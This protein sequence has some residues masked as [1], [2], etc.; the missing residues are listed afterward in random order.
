MSQ[1]PQTGAAQKRHIEELQRDL[2]RL[3]TNL[4]FADLSL[5]HKGVGSWT[6]GSPRSPKSHSIKSRAVHPVKQILTKTYRAPSQEPVAYESEPRAIATTPSSLD[7][8]RS[9]TRV[10]LLTRS[11]WA[12]VIDLFF[13]FAVVSGALLLT[14]YVLQIGDLLNPRS[15]LS[16]FSI[17]E[18]A[19]GFGVI[20]ALYLLFFKLLFGRSPG[21]LL[22][23]WLL[24]RRALVRN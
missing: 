23:T 13:L 1:D 16:W 21:A 6:V 3:A 7:L 17:H 12:L 11:I 4:S 5:L 24:S 9:E 15:W 14:T 18:L 2:A 22:A 10:S 20:L 19:A 8:R